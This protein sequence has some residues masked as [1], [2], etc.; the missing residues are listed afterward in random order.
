MK[1]ISIIIDILSAL[2]SFKSSKPTPKRV[3]T[4]EDED[5]FVEGKDYWYDWKDLDYVTFWTRMI[6]IEEGG[7]VE[8][9]AT[10]YGLPGRRGHM[11]V[12]STFVNHFGNDPAF[13]QAMMTARQQQ[14]QG[15]MSNAA[16][17]EGLLEP[18]EG[19]DLETY[20]TIASKL[21]RMPDD[22]AAQ[23]KLLA[24]SGLDLEIYERVNQTWMSRMRSSKDPM[25]AAAIA[26]EYAKY[27]GAASSGSHTG[28]DGE[29][30]CTLEKY[31]EIMGAQSAWADDGRDIHAMLTETFGLTV[32][33]YS[34]LGMY[35]N[36]RTMSDF[37]LAERIND[38]SESYRGQYRTQSPDMDLSL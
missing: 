1:I 34:D 16:A 3:A 35:W 27:F 28:N 19:V 32:T 31:A 17:N 14:M 30:P 24:G 21:S 26:T 33:D 15:Q 9:T 36:Q 8:G 10:K 38:L 12:K 25:G 22:I 2:L 37:R 13:N 7:D 29:Q 23:N 11:R 4:V 20:A 6:E 18:V 5:P